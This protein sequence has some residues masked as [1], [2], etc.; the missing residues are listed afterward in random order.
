MIG[1][2]QCSPT[3]YACVLDFAKRVISLEDAENEKITAPKG[4]SE[5]I[6]NEINKLREN[7][8]EYAKLLQK[9]YDSFLDN[10]TYQLEDE[11][12]HRTT[13]GKECKLRYGFDCDTAVVYYDMSHIKHMT[14]RWL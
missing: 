12:I 8:A 3:Y 10:H 6:A 13:E 2:A 11:M 14:L 1:P 5:A 4:I 9:R 7:P